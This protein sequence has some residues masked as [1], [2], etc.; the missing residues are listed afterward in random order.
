[1]YQLL[2][3]FSS[4]E[5]GYEVLLEKSLLF[6]WFVLFGEFPGSHGAGHCSGYHNKVPKCGNGSIQADSVL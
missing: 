2:L 5:V 6:Y 4:R 1:M 3:I